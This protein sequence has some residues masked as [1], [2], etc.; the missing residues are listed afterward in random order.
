MS[1]SP[2]TFIGR[3]RELELLA[4]AYRSPQSS[5]IPIY[6]RRRVGKSEL[7]LR[8]MKGKS[9]VYLLGKQ[10]RARLQIRELL[11][12]AATAMNQPLLA[13]F[14]A[15]DWH[16][17]LSAVVGAHQQGKLILVFDEF[18]WTV[19]ASPELPS[20]LQGL[21]DREWRDSGKV[22]LILCGSYVGFMERKILGKKAPL[23][24]RRTAQI[25]LL[26]FD[27]LEAA[28]FHPSYS[29]VD[30][31]RTYFLCGGVPQYLRSFDPDRSVEMNIRACFLNE[32]APLYQEPD[33]L[34]REELREV[35]TYSA[36]LF[37]LAAGS[38]PPAAIAEQIGIDN[39]ALHHYLKQ[40]VALGYISRRYPLT[41]TRPAAR[42]VRYAIDDPMLRFWFRFVYPNTSFISLM[43][44]EKA[45]STRIEPYLSAYF[46]LC[47]ERLCREA[48]P[49]IYRR[50][51]VSAAF[52][53][54]EYWDK[55][56]QIDVVGLR[57]DGWTD[58]GECKWGTDHSP[59]ALTAELEAKVASYP[60]QRNATIGRRI[61]TRMPVRKKPGSA[62]T[63]YCLEDLYHIGE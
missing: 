33:F 2:G 21:W 15:D 40:L 54:G 29:T 34:L 52:T 59:S 41:S 37:A 45:F 49:Y 62:A 23:F 1:A 63:W 24:G 16:T 4:S 27:F 7:I 11:V 55:T 42:H 20:V 22:M 5:F 13:G 39:R 57:D 36:V 31:A 46:G 12:E 26:P 28:A 10:A 43:G 38:R 3:K 9:G 60:N 30:Q 19:G 35:E 14:S 25:R 17:A 8:F 51:G 58:L 53:I 47:F 48:L 61:F 18:Q 56:A 44:E 32:H 50:E 6:G